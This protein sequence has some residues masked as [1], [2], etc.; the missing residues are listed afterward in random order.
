MKTNV[1][2]WYFDHLFLEWEMFQKKIVEKIK[3]LISFAGSFYF[4]NRSVY[5]IMW[6]KIL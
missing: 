3:T 4:E 5:E 6:E 2:F 1:H